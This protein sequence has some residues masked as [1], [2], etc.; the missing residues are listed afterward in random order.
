MGFQTKLISLLV[1]LHFISVAASA[2]P[3]PAASYRVI[4]DEKQPGIIRVEADL[5]PED[6]LLYMHEDGAEQFPR[7][8]AHFVKTL[9]I[10]DSAGR[11]I[12][13]EELPDAKWRI[14]T[15]VQGKLSV[16]YE[17]TIEH[18]N[19]SWPGGIDGVAFSRDSGIFATGRT[20]L[21][22][23]GRRS[24]NIRVTFNLPAFWRVTAPWAP[25][26]EN[27]YI[28]RDLTDLRESMVQIG[29]HDEFSV[30][31][32]GFE[33]VF[34]LAGK[35]IASQKA[36]YE[37]L[38]NGV[39]DYY[40]R[41]MGGIPNPP[42]ARP[43]KRVV[44]IVNAGKDVDGEVIGNHISMILDPEADAFSQVISK[45]I[46][47]HE[48]FHLWN[49][50]SINVASTKEDWFKEGITNYYTLKALLHTGA[51]TEKEFFDTLSNLFYKRYAADTGYGKESMRD[52][53]AGASKDKHWGLIYGGGL[54]AGMCQDIAV[55]K[56][57][58][59]RRSLDDLM[60]AFFKKYGGTDSTYTTSDVQNYLTTLGG[61][62]QSDFFA[63]H[64]F[65]TVPVPIEKCLS[66]AGF[67]AKITGGELV[68]SRRPGSSPGGKSV[69]DSVPGK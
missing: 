33:L 42:P 30:R 45:F 20:F 68:V 57:S 8:W 39:L 53:A 47:A 19:H 44:V 64:V 5:V 17:V 31:R 32:N 66:E 65:G 51:I 34:A 56:A 22:M 49:G 6:N 43:F 13:V 2:Q 1:L 67:D 23:N 4:V 61:T 40:I 18:G 25:Q 3:S 60:R 59:N 62:D 36:A 69:L 21:V 28:A 12:P 9:T 58:S 38:A 24:R 46:F 50:K 7:R 48:F 63:R 16:S 35:G 29:K 11:A 27:T 10:K 55:R 41:L 15:P 14:K 37:K 26:S 54:F 52:V